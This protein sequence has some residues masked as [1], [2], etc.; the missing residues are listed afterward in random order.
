MEYLGR[1]DA[2]ARAIDRRLL[3]EENSASHHWGRSDS[4][5]SAPLACL[6]SLLRRFGLIGVCVSLLSIWPSDLTQIVTGNP[7]HDSERRS[8][9]ERFIQ[10]DTPLLEAGKLIEKELKAGQQHFYRFPLNHGQ[11][12]RITVEQQRIDVVIRVTSADGGLVARMDSPYGFLGTE[13]VSVLADVSGNYLVELLAIGDTAAVGRYVLSAEAPREP[14]P[15]DLT[16]IKAERAFTQAQEKHASHSLLEAIDKYKEALIDWVD[17]S[18]HYWEAKTLYELA[19]ATSESGDKKGAEQLYRQAL[20]LQES[21]N[22]HRGQAFSLKDLGLLVGMMGSL[23]ESIDLSKKALPLWQQDGDAANQAGTFNNL[24]VALGRAG[25]P[26]QAISCHHQALKLRDEL[27]D[28]SGKAQSLNNIGTVYDALGDPQAA[29]DYY[30]RASSILVGIANPTR[31]D[32]RRLATALNNIGYAYALV[33]EPE[34][35]LNYYE[36]ALPIRK[37]VD[38]SIGEGA[39]LTNIGSAYLAKDDVQTALRYYDEALKK[40]NRWG[41]CY[42]LM[43]IGDANLKLGDK[44]KALDIYEQTLKLFNELQDVQGEAAILDKMGR[45]YTTLGRLQDADDYY[46]RAL[47]RWREVRDRRG[48]ATTLQALALNRARNNLLEGLKL[49]EAAIGIVEELRTGIL[50]PQLR[51]SYFA[52]VRDCYDLEIDMLMQMHRLHPAEGYDRRALETS[53]R[54]RAR[55]LLETLGE[56]HVGPSGMTASALTERRTRLI[57]RLNAKASRRLQTSSAKEESASADKEIQGLSE[58]IQTLDTQIGSANPQYSAVFGRKTLSVAGIQKYLDPDTAL[59]EFALEEPRSYLWVVTEKNVSSFEL[60]GRAEIDSAASQVYILLT[61]RNRNLKGESQTQKY[62]R[63]SRAEMEYPK[64]AAALAQMLFGSPR[65]LPSSK[66][67]LIVSDGKLQYIPFGALPLPSLAPEAARA[68]ARI[69]PGATVTRL[70]TQGKEST[71]STGDQ[72]LL[73]RYEVIHLP[74]GSVLGVLR[75]QLEGRT[76]APKAVAVLADPVFNKDDARLRR[77]DAIEGTNSTASNLKATRLSHVL[78]GSAIA[79]EKSELPRLFFSRREADSIAA[80]AGLEQTKEALGFDASRA[81][82]ISDELSQFRIVHFSA[83]GLVNDQHPERSGIVLSLIDKNGRPQDG[84][85]TLDDIYGLHLRADLA[86]LSA[87]QTAFGKDVRGEGL[88]S[89]T[90]GF[91]YAGAPRVV[92][93]LWNVDDAATAELMAN[94]YSLMLRTGQRPAEALRNAQLELLKQKRWRQPYFWAAFVI[95]G[96]WN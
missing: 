80:A 87:C 60:P 77:Q 90:R 31:E 61:A 4:G 1:C 54:S 93:S 44:Q 50:A 6:Q 23:A 79:G 64:A 88:I 13:S 66:R 37:E 86:V 27:G 56:A 5:F 29:L 10:G 39:T 55:V 25:D 75:A 38:D 24:G 82:A 63:I 92:A 53:E 20:S 85:L 49:N 46:E 71:D 57:H 69:S 35:A 21:I 19:W 8:S 94:F 51:A 48:E 89:L 11:F 52:S 68:D 14:A 18:D 17:I 12:L 91:M 76:R 40:Q 34:M 3:T 28:A 83:H 96:E 65:V 43:N 58:E 2:Q 16:R 22:D 74:S 95:Q 67:L 41:K 78:A 33:S 45:A 36:Q 70:R 15:Q 47:K 26:D 9:E 42:T 32:R 73:A 7:I 84:F 72:P 30:N 62:T 59:M 81:T